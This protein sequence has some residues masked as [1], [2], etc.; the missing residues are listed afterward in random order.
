MFGHRYFGS[1]YFGPRYWGDGSAAAAVDVDG[2]LSVG[3]VVA[4]TFI[5]AFDAPPVTPTETG[6][7][8][9]VGGRAWREY[10]KGKNRK[11][12]DALSELDELIGV[13]RAQI[14][15]AP[16]Y[17][18]EHDLREA[19]E[20]CNAIDMSDTVRRIETEIERTKELLAEVDDE[21]AV[22][23]LLV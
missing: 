10:Y 3:A 23:V 9:G 2:A 5:G 22:F 13:L 17:D 14:V 6:G 18:Q 19:L 1:R 7:A 15:T 21:E 8:V 4:A 20:R 12:K 16:S 11:K